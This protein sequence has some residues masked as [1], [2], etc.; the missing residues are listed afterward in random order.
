MLL[1]FVR[2]NWVD[3]LLFNCIFG[4]FQW[5]N[6]RNIGSFFVYHPK[7]SPFYQTNML[8]DG[9][10]LRTINIWSSF[11]PI[12]IFLPN[13]ID[14]VVAFKECYLPVTETLPNDK[15]LDWQ[16]FRLVQFQ[17]ICRWQSKCNL[18]IKICFEEGRKHCGNRRKCWL[19]V[20]SPFHRMFSKAFSLRSL[21]VGI[22]R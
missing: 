1:I 5:E 15:I 2:F 17:G 14:E 4:R 20:F 13:T 3:S 9:V 6:K 11:A 10:K 8:N 18:N 7:F 12:R 19:P 16:N 21:K 22:M